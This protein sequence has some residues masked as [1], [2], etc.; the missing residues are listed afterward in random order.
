MNAKFYLSA[1]AGTV[2]TFLLGWLIYGILLK[3]F[4]EANTIHYEGL[5]PE[6]PNMFLLILSNLFM[7][8][9]IAFVFQRWAGFNT[10]RNGLFGGMIIGF[11]IS[12][13][14]DLSMFSMMNLVTPVFLIVDILVY[15]FMTGITGGVIAAVQ[16]YGKNKGT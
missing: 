1:L 4:S 3:G 14:F 13:A 15:T 12:A 2:T 9:F 16:G 10:F 8:L 5:M 7:A 6:M 11:F